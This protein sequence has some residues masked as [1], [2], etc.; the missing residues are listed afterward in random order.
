MT[1]LFDV[2][3]DGSVA[4]VSNTLVCEVSRIFFN[5]DESGNDAP[6]W[7]D[8]R[9]NDAWRLVDL[10]TLVEAVVLHDT[11][12]T[13]PSRL[14]TKT[15]ELTLRHELLRYEILKELDS[16]QFHLEISNLITNS[17]S[18]IKD[19]VKV[20]GS[21]REIGTPIDF[22]SN[23]RG[24]IDGFFHD[25]GQLLHV[26]DTHDFY[27]EGGNSVETL[28]ADSY[29]AMGK[30]LIG[31]IEYYGSGAYEH[32]TSILRDMYYII[33]SERRAL[34]YWPQ[35]SRI[36]FSKKFPN[37]FDK[38]F[39]LQLYSNLAKALDSTVTDV[40]DDLNQEVAFIPPFT[41]LVLERSNKPEDI[42]EQLFIIRDEYTE[43]RQ[44]FSTLENER[45]NANSLKERKQ[46]RLRQKMLLEKA[47]SSFEEPATITLQNIVKYIPEVIKTA[48]APVNPANYSADL[49]LRPTDWIVE[50][51]QK[52][53][54]S[55]LFNLSH[56]VEKIENY[57]KLIQKVFGSRFD[58]SLS[59]RWPHI[60]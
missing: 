17:L 59:Y 27:G 31:W 30:S 46:I 35:F 19:P 11:L 4:L 7:S 22:E 47:A 12:V 18:Q 25:S 51:W 39:S 10:M 5:Q 9:R 57:H 38:T 52:R 29:E 28:Y 41:T 16:S 42:I 34:P 56:R 23:I 24:K 58:D 2:P 53:P 60:R 14:S 13:L 32:C 21:W 36:E 49:F 45:Q 43:L 55:K 33:V 6:R 44:G 8:Y 20:A 48:T 1:K 37:Y 40:F 54:V 15:K 3:Q 50:W 26:N